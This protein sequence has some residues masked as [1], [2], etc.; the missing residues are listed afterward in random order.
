MKRQ[1]KLAF[2]VPIMVMTAL[3]GV[4]VPGGSPSSR[5][6]ASAATAV[7]SAQ[8]SLGAATAVTPPRGN[9]EFNATFPG[10]RLNARVWDT[11]YPKAPH[12]PAHP[13]CTNYGNREY[14]WYLPSQVKV[15][16]GYL[17]LTARPAMTVGATSTGKAKVYECRSGMVT[18]YPG[19]RFKYGFVQV[20]ADVPHAAGLW[21]A[22]WLA[23]ANGQFPPEIDLLESWGVD[24]LE[25]VFF[26]PVGAAPDRRFFPVSLTRG[27]QTYSLSWTKSRLTFYVGNKAELTVTK[28]VPQQV[29]YFIANVAEYVSPKAG[30]CSGTMLI[31]SV[32]IWKL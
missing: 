2:G 3:W 14:E 29:M 15:S 30:T 22:L 20:V 27:W 26:H 10:S 24:H 4:G 5:A 6:G 31:K 13:G 18:S 7:R 19:F 16:G 8:V 1:R 17:R 11:C 23:A 9:P 21:P 25:A 12:F 32:K 28:R